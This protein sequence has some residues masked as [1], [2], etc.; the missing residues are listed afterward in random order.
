MEEFKENLPL[1]QTL[2][3]PG[4]RDRHWE[5]VSEIVG[6]PIK[7]DEETCLSKFVDMN[8]GAYVAKFESVSEAATKEFSLEKA[9]E[10]MKIEWAPVSASSFTNLSSFVVSFPFSSSFYSILT[11]VVSSSPFISKTENIQ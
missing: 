5:Q 7:P 8:L 2:F 1:I 10:K 4:M 11:R 9:L 6:Y 3:N